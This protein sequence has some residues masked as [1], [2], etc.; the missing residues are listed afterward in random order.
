MALTINRPHF[1][2][3]RVLAG[4]VLLFF[5]FTLTSCKDAGDQR[6]TVVNSPPPSK[7]FTFFD[8]GARSAFSDKIKDAL[9]DNL[10]PDAYE[11]RTTIDLELHDKGFLATHFPELDAL[12][13]QLNYLPGERVEHNTI[14][15][16]YRYARRKN[17]PFDFV[18]LIFSSDTRTPLFFKIRA[19]NEG[20]QVLE[21]IREKYGPADHRT[22][23]DGNGQSHFWKQN[24]EMLVISE[25]QTRIGTPQYLFGFY[26]INNIKAMIQKEETRRL[27]RREAREKTGQT[28]F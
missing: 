18:R 2:F 16:T 11:T 8:L 28:A 15:L 3:Q 1:P 10:G 22:W 25:T 9:E 6:T 20:A 27:Q 23:A 13:R 24:G 19:K 17:A 14:Q 12:N 7:G 21:K 4:V 5:S 26:F